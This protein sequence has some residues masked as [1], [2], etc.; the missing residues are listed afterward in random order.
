MKEIYVVRGIVRH[1]D[2]YL[3]LKKIKDINPDNDGKWEVPG[4]RF[5]S[6]EDPQTALKRELEE[7]TGLK[8]D[9]DLAL[10]R[11]LPS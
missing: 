11:Q 3:L 7:E 1:G 5:K 2:K 8:F 4:G 9:K 6:D 10:V